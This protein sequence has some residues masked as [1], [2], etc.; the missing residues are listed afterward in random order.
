[1][2]NQ[3]GPPRIERQNILYICSISQYFVVYKVKNND[4][5]F[6]QVTAS[7]RLTIAFI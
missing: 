2:N 6:F 5:K 1:M 7:K 3:F 4:E